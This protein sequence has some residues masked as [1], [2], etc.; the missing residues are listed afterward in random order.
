MKLKDP[1]KHDVK[2]Y[3]KFVELSLSLIF[4]LFSRHLCNPSTTDLQHEQDWLANTPQKC[5][6]VAAWHIQGSLFTHQWPLGAE[7]E[8]DLQLTKILPEQM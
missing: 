3:S 4:C 1:S 6:V 5:V 2:S 7:V 8:N